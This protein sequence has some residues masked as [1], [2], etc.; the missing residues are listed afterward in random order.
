[1]WLALDIH[2]Y[3]T[4]KIIVPRITKTIESPIVSNFLAVTSIKPHKSLQYQDKERS[5]SSQL[6]ARSFPFL[7]F[8]LESLYALPLYFQW[9]FSYK[10]PFLP[11]FC[12]SSNSS[13]KQKT[14]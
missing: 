14:L 10:L 8:M 5:R 6:A 9:C 3:S 11:I 7:V 4:A 2:S 13:Q 12:T 1:M